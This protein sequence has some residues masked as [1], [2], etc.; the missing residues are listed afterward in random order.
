M[1][2]VHI[3][4]KDNSSSTFDDMNLECYWSN[5]TV[6]FSSAHA[7][8]GVMLFLRQSLGREV[9]PITNVTT[10]LAKTRHTRSLIK[11]LSTRV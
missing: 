10:V 6:F 1:R 9:G 7:Q 4:V 3:S 5:S 2:I 8:S 11:V